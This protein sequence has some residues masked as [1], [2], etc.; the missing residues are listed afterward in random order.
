MTMV[1]CGKDFM[2]KF[3]HRQATNFLSIMTL[4]GVLLSLMPPGF[5]V[6]VFEKI[7]IKFSLLS[8]KKARHKK[9]NI[10]IQ[11]QVERKRFLSRSL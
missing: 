2:I 1:E 8:F 6:V 3:H 7:P 9:V 10:F 11:R 5:L 4:N